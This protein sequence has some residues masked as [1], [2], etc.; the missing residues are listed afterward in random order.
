MS[1]EKTLGIDLGTTNSGM[2]LVEAGDPQMLQ[3]NAGERLTPS[4]VY[5]DEDEYKVGRRAIRL[6]ERNPDQVIREIKRHMGE[7]T[8][9]IGGTEYSPTDVSADILRK[10]KSDAEEYL[11]RDVTNAVVTVPAYFRL[12]QR[13]ATKQAADKAGF[14]EYRLLSEPTAAA[15]AYGNGKDL[16]ETILVYDFGGGTLDISLIDVAD[17]EYKVLATSGDNK[18][19]GK[20]FDKEMMEL[21]ADRLDQDT[22]RLLEDNEISASLR[23][24]AEEAKIDL[25]SGETV[26]ALSNFLGQLDGEVI[27]IDEEVTRETFE[28]ATEHL[29]DDAVD[30]VQDALDRASLTTEDLDT[31]LL[32]GGSTQIP[33]VQDR[34]EAYVGI[35]P[36]MT[37]DPDQI[38][39]QGAAVFAQRELEPGY[40]CAE[41]G[42]EFDTLQGLNDHYNEEGPG[43]EESDEIT[44]PYCDETFDSDQDLKEHQ[45]AEHK[46]KIEKPPGGFVQATA[47]DLGTKLKDG[48]MAVLIEGST[49]YEDASGEDIFTTARDNQEIVRV[50]VYEGDSEIAEENTYIGEVVLRDIEPRPAGEPRIAVEFDMDEDGILFVEAKDKDSEEKV[51]A[52]LEL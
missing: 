32:A 12:D 18:L 31:V 24:V 52:E 19:G 26:E 5:Y 20:D 23:R 15:V 44:C 3:N 43:D 37:L 51:D 8:V 9:D 50:E 41:C 10:I 17:E 11:E 16:D 42:K 45:G 28:D 1:D 36:T 35:E 2:A 7:D 46:G 21:L 38:V 49:S 40:R 39:A 14:E 29:L 27:S 47:L 33:A 22:E 48:S 13:E 25:S 6:E 4:V 34:L 30:P